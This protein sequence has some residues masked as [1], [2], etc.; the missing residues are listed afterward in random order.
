MGALQAF[1]TASKTLRRNPI[2]FVVTAAIS[3]FQLPGLVAQS[4]DP[5]LGSLISL[6]FSG[7]LL[8]VMP[9]FIG[10]VI[11][12]ANEATSGRTTVETF[13]SEGKA[14][15]VSILAV[16]FG[17]LILYFVLG[18][19]GFFALGVGGA[20]LFASGSQPGLALLAVLAVISLATLFVY[21]AVLFVSQFFG[22]A[23]VIDNLGAIDGL[24]RSLW[25]VRHNI[26]SVLGY[27]IIVTVGGAVLGVFGALYSLLTRP[28]FSAPRPGMTEVGTSPA[29]TPQLLDVPSV[30]IAGMVG[31]VVVLLLVSSLFGGFFA[32]YS[33][34]F[35]RSIRPA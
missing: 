17:L 10:G 8:F 3:L 18:F 26:V 7:L 11:G 33:T 21:F 9:F 14:H 13:V 31:L 25:C 4:I 2:L 12:M 23:I 28:S 35:Y 32:A 6:V 5:L 22:H 34:A 15:Y 19:I 16:Y 29:V 27:T 1:G 24:K 30:G 20:L